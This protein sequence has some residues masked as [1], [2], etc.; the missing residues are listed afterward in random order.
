MR[1]S[2]CGHNISAL[3]DC[4]SGAPRSRSPS[5]KRV[6]Q[7]S[8]PTGLWK[9]SGSQCH[10][11]PGTLCRGS[12]SQ[13]AKFQTYRHHA[14]RR[15]PR[16]ENGEIPRGSA[17]TVRWKRVSVQVLTYASFHRTPFCPLRIQGGCAIMGVQNNSESFHIQK[18]IIL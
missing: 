6:S 13:P 4:L 7:A 15:S 3:I 8:M 12:A 10:S 5:G 1:R 11:M 14:Q 17:Q 16:D 18:P 9:P 2:L